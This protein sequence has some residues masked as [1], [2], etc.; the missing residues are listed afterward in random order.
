MVGCTCDVSMNGG[1]IQYVDYKGPGAVGSCG[2]KFVY[3]DHG[4]TCEDATD[5]SS[6]T[7]STVIFDQ[8]VN[9]VSQ[10]C[11]G[12]RMGKYSSSG[13]YKY[14]FTCMYMYTYNFLISI[15]AS[16]YSLIL[17]YI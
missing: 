5:F 9:A 15:P 6:G 7:F 17:R 13:V 3:G 11:F 4:V 16:L 2:I 14:L 1:S 10:A 12:I 8:T